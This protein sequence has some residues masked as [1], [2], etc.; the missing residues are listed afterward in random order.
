MFNDMRERRHGKIRETEETREAGRVQETKADTGSMGIKGDRGVNKSQRICVLH[1]TL[2]IIFLRAVMQTI[3]DFSYAIVYL[4]KH[5]ILPVLT[6]PCSMPAG[7]DLV[8]SHLVVITK[9]LNATKGAREALTQHY[10]QE[11]WLDQIQN[12]SED[13]L[14]RQALQRMEIDPSQYDKFL[15]MLRSIKGLDI[16]VKS[17][18]R[19]QGKD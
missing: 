13:E 8:K 19:V 17:L 16:V 14:V 7:Y 6:V 15:T 3:N 10:V 12:P 11:G 4:E 18:T 9:L 5:N 2:Q 1:K